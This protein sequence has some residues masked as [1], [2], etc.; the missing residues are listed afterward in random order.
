MEQLSANS[1]EKPKL[2]NLKSDDGVDLTV[3]FAKFD[4]VLNLSEKLNAI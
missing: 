1:L 3:V 2:F 4:K